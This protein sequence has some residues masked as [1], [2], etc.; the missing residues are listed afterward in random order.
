MID[1]GYE[2]INEKRQHYN[3]K[4]KVPSQSSRCVYDTS[5]WNLVNPIAVN[6]RARQHTS[7]R[8]YQELWLQ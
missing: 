3:G 4:S 2:W 5:D 6:L 1:I 8:D 7:D